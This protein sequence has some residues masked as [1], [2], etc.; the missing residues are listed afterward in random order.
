MNA[1]C[2]TNAQDVI[3][4]RIIESLRNVFPY[5]DLRSRIN[6]IIE[7]TKI[8]TAF[9]QLHEPPNPEW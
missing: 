5:M 9:H 2:C 6:I 7:L 8:H 4:K 1:A 3:V